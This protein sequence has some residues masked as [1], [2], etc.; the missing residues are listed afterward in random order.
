MNEKVSSWNEGV[1]KAYVSA[2]M[3]LS[4]PHTPTI[5]APIAFG[6]T[7][8]AAYKTWSKFV[9]LGAKFYMEEEEEE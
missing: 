1:L 8:K 4:D 9:K 5:Y 6:F 7:N 3:S 2:I